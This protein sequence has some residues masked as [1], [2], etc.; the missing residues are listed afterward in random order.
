MLRILLAAAALLFCCG[1]TR[2]ETREDHIVHR[3]ETAVLVHHDWK[4][5]PVAMD[6]ADAHAMANAAESA[7][8]AVKLAGSG[9]LLLV[10]AGA[11]VRIVSES[12][13]EREV[14]IEDG[15]YAGRTGWVPY[16]WLKPPH[17]ER[18]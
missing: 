6:K 17:K 5:V 4:T 9:Q 12:Y 1:C 13:N 11:R 15:E 18:H 14:R 16:E 3:G 8:G 7:H 2:L 10:P